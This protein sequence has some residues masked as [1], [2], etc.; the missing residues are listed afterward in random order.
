MTYSRDRSVSK[1]VDRV[2]G[3]LSLA[4]PELR[5]VVN[6]SYSEDLNATPGCVI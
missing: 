5:D 2:H 1:P 3:V 4:R 6:A